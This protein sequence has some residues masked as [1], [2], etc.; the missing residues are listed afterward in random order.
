MGRNDDHI[1]CLRFEVGPFNLESALAVVEDENFGVRMPMASRT[2]ARRDFGDHGRGGEAMVR[3]GELA[4]LPA[5]AGHL[6][7]EQL[8]LGMAHNAGFDAIGHGPVPAYIGS[9]IPPC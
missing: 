8:E 5:I 6:P 1:A 3:P 7:R 9:P 2:A 4:Q